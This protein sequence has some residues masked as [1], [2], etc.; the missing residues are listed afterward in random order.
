MTL[1]HAWAES[2]PKTMKPQTHSAP[3]HPALVARFQRAKG[4]RMQIPARTKPCA[5]CPWILKGALP[6]VTMELLEAAN[7]QA[8]FFCHTAF[9]CGPATQ[10]VGAVCKGWALKS[11]RLAG[12]H[13]ARHMGFL[14]DV[15]DLPRSRWRFTRRPS[16]ACARHG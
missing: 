4:Y 2:G 1:R 11:K 5:S 10:R 16:R 7:A 3:V 6:E 13:L 15:D 9:A 8:L 12:F 14:V